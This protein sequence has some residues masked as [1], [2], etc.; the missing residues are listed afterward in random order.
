M[1]DKLLLNDFFG[2]RTD[3][4]TVEEAIARPAVKIYPNPARGRVF[5]ESPETMS[6]VWLFDMVGTVVQQHKV[7]A[8]SFSFDLG[9]IPPGMYML[10][11]ITIGQKQQTFRIIVH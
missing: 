10:R 6:A 7:G 4:T 8:A 9:G 2:Y 1:P 3:P 11:V 5:L